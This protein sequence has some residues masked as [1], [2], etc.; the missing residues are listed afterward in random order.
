MSLPEVRHAIARFRNAGMVA[1]PALT[2]EWFGRAPFRAGI[3]PLM[4]IAREGTQVGEPVNAR[5]KTMPL[6]ASSCIAGVRTTLLP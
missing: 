1:I 3:S 4:M 6:A 5:S 2:P